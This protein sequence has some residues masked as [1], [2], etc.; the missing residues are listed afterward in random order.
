M[1]KKLKIWVEKKRKKVF[2]VMAGHF[3]E[4][5]LRRRRSKKKK[6]K[7]N[8]KSRFRFLVRVSVKFGGGYCRESRNG[9]VFAAE[10]GGGGAVAHAEERR[11]RFRDSEL[12]KRR[13]ERQD[14]GV[15]GGPAAAIG[16]AKRG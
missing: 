2:F 12:P 9:D 13:T 1:Q 5:V 6:K 14:G 7:P 11:L 4:K 16:F 3:A 10:E 8:L 15:S